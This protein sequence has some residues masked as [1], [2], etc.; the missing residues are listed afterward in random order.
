MKSTKRGLIKVE[1]TQILHYL[2]KVENLFSKD[3]RHKK[4]KTMNKAYQ[5]I[6]KTVECLR[7]RN[8]N[9]NTIV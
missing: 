1:C 8:N 6:R 7:E 2:V 5:L 3:P 9:D 4:E